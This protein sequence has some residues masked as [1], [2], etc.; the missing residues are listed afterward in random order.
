ML[1]LSPDTPALCRPPRR[2]L[3]VYA[4]DGETTELER[5]S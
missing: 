4:Y 2:S 5:G 1:H 3:L